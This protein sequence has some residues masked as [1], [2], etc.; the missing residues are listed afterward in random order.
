MNGLENIYDLLDYI[1]EFGEEYTDQLLSIYDEIVDYDDMSDSFISSMEVAKGGFDIKSYLMI[2]ELYNTIQEE[3]LEIETDASYVTK[4]MLI[5][6][7]EE[8]Q[9]K[10]VNIAEKHSLK[11]VEIIGEI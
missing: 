6:L 2:E 9:S 7:H 11:G 3:L 4:I 5:S 8:K 10:I 1:N